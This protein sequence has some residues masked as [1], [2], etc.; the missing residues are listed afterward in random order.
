MKNLTAGA[1]CLFMCSLFLLS[2][3]EQPQVSPT[4]EKHEKRYPDLDKKYIYQS[5]IRL[6][7]IKRDPD[8]EKLI[9][10]VD[11]I[12]LYFPPDGDTTYQIKDLKQGMRAD[13]Y[14][15]LVDV[16]TAD[17]QRVSLWVKESGKRSHFIALMD[18]SAE[19]L[20]LEIDGQLNL[21]YLSAIS[22][23]NQKSL[24]DLIQ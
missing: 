15:T 17:N 5:V 2:G 11:K 19:D 4:L 8:F 1:F 20:I 16:R 18:G 10:D 24:M 22:V 7:N 14:E 6:A 13:G 21:E 9:Q 12:I 23:A 3:C